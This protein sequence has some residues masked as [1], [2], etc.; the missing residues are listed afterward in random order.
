MSVEAVLNA[1]YAARAQR[2]DEEDRAT[3]MLGKPEDAMARDVLDKALGLV[4]S[5]VAD[6]GSGATNVIQLRAFVDHVN[7]TMR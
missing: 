1:A 5:P 3:R 2:A 4:E 6:A 7:A